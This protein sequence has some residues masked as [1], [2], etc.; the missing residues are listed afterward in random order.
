[1]LIPARLIRALGVST[2]MICWR[3]MGFDY[4]Q[5]I[6]SL[7]TE[8]RLRFYEILA[9]NLTVSVRAIW[10]DEDLSDAQKVEGMKWVNEIM[11]RIVQK[12]AAL[13]LSRND[14]S[15]EATWGTITHWV[16]QSALISGHVGWAIKASYDSCRR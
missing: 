6:G 1:M 2:C 14:F 10:S 8:E 4:P 9:H 3:E 16:S 15:E 12:S 5:L 13:R 11:H 7:N